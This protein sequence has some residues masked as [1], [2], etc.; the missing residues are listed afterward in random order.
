M[1]KN[2]VKISGITA[3]TLFYSRIQQ[4]GWEY[5]QDKGENGEEWGSTQW[6]H[7]EDGPDSKIYPLIL[8][9]NLYR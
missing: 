1:V 4:A 2:E 3:M 6:H 7:L 9:L 5:L 8:Y